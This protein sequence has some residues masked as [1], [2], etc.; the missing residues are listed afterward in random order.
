MTATPEYVG[1]VAMSLDG[2]IAEEDGGVGWLEQFD[3]TVPAKGAGSY[4]D[5][6]ARIDALVMGRTTFEQVIGFGW[7]YGDLPCYVLTRDT[8]YSGEHVTAAGGI[9][10]LGAAIASA[11]H[12]RVWVVGGGKTQRTA[13]DAGM[14]DSAQVFVIADPSGQG[15]STFRAGCR[16][17][18]SNAVEQPARRCDRNHLQIWGLDRWPRHSHP[19]AT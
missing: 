17:P 9:E 1:Y 12:A 4:S 15:H 2:F 8:G 18:A 13:L 14:F 3:D 7:P 16:A 5:F 10:N 19:Q 11:G 6:I